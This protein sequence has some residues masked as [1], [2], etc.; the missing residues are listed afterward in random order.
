MNNLKNCP[1]YWGGF[2]FTPYYFEFWEGHKSRI[3]K[4]L[5]FK[6][7]EKNWEKSIIQP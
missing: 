4:R 2:A 1:D 6:K 3:N 7:I 5:V